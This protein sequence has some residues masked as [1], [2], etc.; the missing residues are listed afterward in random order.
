M[1]S[2]LYN[3]AHKTDTAVIIQVFE[4]LILYEEPMPMAHVQ[5]RDH[6]QK[7]VS[8]KYRSTE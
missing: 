1:M 8:R 6:I 3:D 7:Q 4:L 5:N 2:S